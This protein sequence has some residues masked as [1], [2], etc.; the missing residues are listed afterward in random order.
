MGVG[1]DL[2]VA[3]STPELERTEPGL[4]QGSTR[5]SLECGGA[6]TGAGPGQA[7][8]WRASGACA[9]G[10]NTGCCGEIRCDP[11]PSETSRQHRPPALRNDG[12][13]YA[14]VAGGNKKNKQQSVWSLLLDKKRL[15]THYYSL[16]YLE[17]TSSWWYFGLF[18][19]SFVRLE[20][21]THEA[22]MH[23]NSFFQ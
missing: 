18:L 20:K 15:S 13:N 19:W 23:F 9:D 22:K 7:T 10:Y 8:Y 4:K 17:L 6:N 12:W 21:T 2:G 3:A 11:S 16:L 14:P 1:L 5:S